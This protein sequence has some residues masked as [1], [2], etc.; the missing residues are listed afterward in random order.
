MRTRLNDWYAI[1][2]VTAAVTP[3]ELKKAYRK[4]ARRHHPDRNNGD[5]EAAA[6]FREITEAYEILSDPALRAEYDRTR[7]PPPSGDTRLAAPDDDTTASR[8]LLVLEDT[9]REIRRQ[10]PEIPAVVII[11]ASGTAGRHP[12]WGHHAAERWQVASEQRTEIMI[13][14]EGLRRTAAEVLGTLLHEAAH[15]LAAARGIKDTSRQGRYHNEKF[16][17]LAR[18]LGIDVAKDPRIGWSITTVPDPTAAAYADQLTALQAAMTLWRCDETLTTT[19]T[20]RSTNLI[21]ATCPCARIIRVA[22]STLA[23]APITCEACSGTFEAR[24]S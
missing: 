1:L 7:P 2:G 12:K 6:R 9:W 3:A 18:E 11:I 15:A 24:A 19:T 10:H 14:G 5:P 17:A 16:A 23:A 4:L 8:L 21:A 22:A 20:R 13:S